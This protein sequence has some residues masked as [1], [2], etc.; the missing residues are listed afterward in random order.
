MIAIVDSGGANITS[1]RFAF[2]RLGVETALTACPKVIQQASHVILPGVGAAQDAMVRLEQH[3]LCDTLRSLTQPVLG[4]CLGMQ[5]LYD[6]SEEGDTACLGILPG[7][8]KALPA[9]PGITVPHMGWNTL[10]QQQGSP[11]LK[12]IADNRYVYFV[13]G[14][15]A[16]VTEHSCATSHHGQTFTAITQ[17]DNFF[18][19]QFHPERSGAAGAQILKNF[20]EAC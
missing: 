18:G 20:Y 14:F 1:I 8:I 11:L 2:E 12:G 7:R 13:H 9:Q 19:A 15:I 3:G 5:L 4:I 10:Q 16:P 6:Y 17:K